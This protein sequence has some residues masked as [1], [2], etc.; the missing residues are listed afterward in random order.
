[1]SRFVVICSLI[2]S[3]FHSI[4]VKMNAYICTYVGQTDGG[5]K[6]GIVANWI[7]ASRYYF[8]AIINWKLPG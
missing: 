2:H 8:V 6:T 7:L 4:R 5:T 3:G 1:M